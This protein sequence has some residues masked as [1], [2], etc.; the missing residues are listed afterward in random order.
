MATPHVT[1]VIALMLEKNP[2][3]VQSTVETILE[4]TALA[5]PPGSMVIWDLVP[6]QGFYTRTW[7]ADATGSG[8]VQADQAIGATP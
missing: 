5:I 4:N 2:N 1:G 3:L 7:G 8:L 6:T